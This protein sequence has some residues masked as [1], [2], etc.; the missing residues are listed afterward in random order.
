MGL[1][2][3]GGIAGHKLFPPEFGGFWLWPGLH[4]WVMGY[5]F[6]LRVKGFPFELGSFGLGVRVTLSG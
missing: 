3:S 5:M 6:G 4:I 1:W 2:H